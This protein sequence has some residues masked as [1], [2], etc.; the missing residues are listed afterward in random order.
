[1]NNGCDNKSK[2]PSDRSYFII[3]YMMCGFS[4]AIVGFL[5]GLLF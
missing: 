4:G 1:M 3:A 5:F 2:N